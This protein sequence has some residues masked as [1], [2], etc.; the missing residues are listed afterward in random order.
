MANNDLT[1]QLTGNYQGEFSLLK[2]STN[3]AIGHMVEIL[4][5]IT[6]S[7][8]QS[9]V[10]I[11]QTSES[12]KYV[13]DEASQQMLAI[14]NV[15]KTIDDTADSV[16]EIARKAQEGSQLACSTANFA[17]D[18]QIQLNKLIELIQHID[19]E[20]VRIEKITDEITRIAD[21]THLLSLNAGL[22]AMR[23]GDYGLGFGF[24]AQQIGA[25]AEE[26]TS[27]ANSIGTV[28]N[29]SGQKFVLA[30]MQCKKLKQ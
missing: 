15:S 30:Y 26:V 3:Q 27:S 7:T 9:A 11:A 14:E 16:G 20:Y 17:N 2:A 8:S 5:E 6:I 10:A 12:S 21:K 24:V 22:E 13:A 25:L 28:I 18:G 19:A 29:S 23:A 4:Q 1:H